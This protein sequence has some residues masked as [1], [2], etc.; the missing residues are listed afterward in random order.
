[1]T[2]VENAKPR[3]TW[4]RVTAAVAAAAL[5]ISMTLSW[6]VQ[7][8]FVQRDYIES[9]L[10]HAAA[11]T[12]ENTEYLSDSGLER[13]WKLLGTVIGRPRDYEDYDTYA[14]IA[15]ARKDYATAAEYMT[16]CI[17]T[18]DGGSSRELGVLYLRLGSLYALTEDEDA[19]I[20][21]FDQAV[22][23]APDLADAYL[24]RA[25]MYGLM[26]NMDAAVED[27]RRYDSLAGAQPEIKTAIGS[28]YESAG[29]YENAIACYTTGINHAENPD[30]QLF[31][32]RAR[33]H[34]LLGDLQAARRDLER[35]F[36]GGGKDPTGEMTVLRGAC[37]MDGQDFEGALRDFHSA[38]RLGHPQKE[39]LYGQCI[40]CAYVTGDYDAVLEDGEALL[41]LME[42][43]GKR[44]VTIGYQGDQ[45]SLAD[46]QRWMG[47]SCLAKQDFAQALNWFEKSRQE[48]PSLKDHSYYLGVCHSA[49]EQYPQAI[50][51]FTASIEKEEM[52]SACLYN[53]GVCYLSREELEAGLTDILTVIQ[54][55]DDPD[56]VSAARE[57]LESM[58]ITVGE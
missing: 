36:A 4:L 12:Q 23:A 20:K 41:E 18:Y 38:I 49:L 13:A 53:R 11:V 54:R 16:G 31:G 2:E 55:N 8:R 25:Q 44:A 19:A 43:G 56:S 21:A 10:E 45:M 35:F 1:M 40:L 9:V 29:D 39:M 22:E 27:I 51:E 5:F 14:S 26:G 58:G 50:E 15:I 52:V 33:C 24:L 34:V 17:E 47:L 7:I 30:P 6:A 46:I 32:S 28:L 3:R 57:L 48:D 42:E 37:L